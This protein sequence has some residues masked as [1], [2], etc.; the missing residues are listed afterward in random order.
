MDGPAHIVGLDRATRLPAQPLH[1]AVGMFDGVHLGHHAVI[2]AAIQSA[3]RSGGVSGVLTFHPHPSAVLA[4]PNPT[5]LIMDA[6][7]KARFLARLGVEYVITQPF[8]PEFAQI[9]AEA[10]LPWLEQRL[11]HLAGLYVGEN[12]RFGRGRRGDVPFLVAVGRRTGLTVFSAPRVNFDGQPINSTRIRSLIESGKISA[13]NELLGY[14]YFAEGVVASGRQLGR[15]LG[16]PTLNLSWTPQLSPRFGV[17][18]VRVSHAS[19]SAGASH[20]AVAN[21]G[22]RPTVDS[23][24]APIL[25]SHLLNECPFREGDAI[26]VE[27]LSFLRPEA[28]FANLDDLRAQIARDVASA[29]KSFEL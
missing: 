29:R 18:A 15:T 19:A 28:K 20:P 5:R 7:T 16:F 21:F 2:D 9:E 14:T 24:S 25:E 10:F 13:A 26:R 22:V 11:S 8:T 27:W 4:S 23:G 1:L 3:R 12:W 17:Y 6:D